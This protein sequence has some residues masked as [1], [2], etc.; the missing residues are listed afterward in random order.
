MKLFGI[1]LPFLDAIDDAI[2]SLN[3]RIDVKR[4]NGNTITTI[5]STEGK[6]TIVNGPG[7]LFDMRSIKYDKD[8]EFNL[9]GIECLDDEEISM[10]RIHETMT[11]K[12]DRLKIAVGDAGFMKFHTG[13][14]AV[15]AVAIEPDFEEYL[16]RVM[17]AYVMK[18]ND[19]NV[20]YDDDEM[21]V[22]EFYDLIDP[23]KFVNLFLSSQTLGSSFNVYTGEVSLGPSE[24]ELDGSVLEQDTLYILH[25]KEILKDGSERVV[26]WST[27]TDFSVNSWKSLV[28]SC[29]G[30]DASIMNAH[31]EAVHHTLIQIMDNDFVLPSNKIQ[32]SH[33]GYRREY[34]TNELSAWGKLIEFAE[35][36]LHAKVSDTFY[37]KAAT[38]TVSGLTASMLAL[39]YFGNQITKIEKETG[40][41]LFYPDQWHEEQ[42]IIR[43]LDKLRPYLLPVIADQYDT[44]D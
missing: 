15:A 5:K 9:P 36:T 24:H 28:D 17:N 43:H 33:I 20:P 6:T 3:L 2:K 4:K 21:M 12:P 30:I 26:M 39:Y 14:G 37:P 23:A 38:T 10:D 31:Y 22:F 8:K 19:V 42:R 34:K 13:G 40:V 11:Q 16:R 27:V 7:G 1:D 44:G 25:V 32:I 29:D 35:G 18:Q 41:T